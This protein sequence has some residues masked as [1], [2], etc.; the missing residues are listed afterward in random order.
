MDV[1]ITPRRLRGTIAAVSSKSDAH[2][3][4]VCAA[5][6]DAPTRISLRAIP[7][8]ICATMACVR[9]LGA[10]CQ[11]GEDGVRVV[12]MASAP[13]ACVLPCGESGS[14][15]RFMLPVAGAL[16][17]PARFS[18]S[19]RLMRRPLKPLLDAMAAGGCAIYEAEGALQLRGRLRPGAYELPGDVSSQFVSGLLFALPLLPG[20]SAIDVAPPFASAGYVEM[21]L[22][23]LESFGVRIAREGPGRFA[24]AGAQRYRSPGAARAEGD[25]SG[26]AFFLAA[27][28]L[29]GDVAVSGLDEG[30]SQADRAIVPLLERLRSAAGDVIIDAEQI[31]DLVPVLAAVAAA[32]PGVRTRIVGAARLRGKESDRLRAMAEG[33]RALGGRADE[34]PDGLD[35][36]GGPLRGGEAD[37]FGD[38]RVVM[39]LAMAACACGGPVRIRGADA[40]GKSYPTFFDDYAL[41]GGDARVL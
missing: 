10:H 36:R 26:A 33:V 11:E 28:A 31:P 32:L 29:G 1:I 19:P 39:A 14:T 16:G 6:A 41:L 3:L 23:T 18:G 4:I 38:H 9:A 30:S 15:L 5:L 12:P 35:I 20:N 21:T 2:R 8:D 37:G 24:A 25:W 7:Q 22:R 27:S 40:V 13:G 17:A 34:Q